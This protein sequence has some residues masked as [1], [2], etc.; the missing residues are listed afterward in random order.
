[1]GNSMRELEA[2]RGD[3]SVITGLAQDK[4]WSNGDG[5]GDHARA[6]ATFL[7]GMQA[8]KT[9]G[10]DIR[11]GV[12]VDQ[13][14]A[15]HMGHL[16][17]L[18]SLELSSDGQR[19][20]GRC[21][22]GYSCAYQF[23]LAWANET[24]P[25]P[26]E[27]DPRLVF[28]RMFGGGQSQGTEA[29][30]RAA[31]RTSILDTVLDDANRISKRANAQDRAKLDEYLT[32]VRDIEQRIQRAE[33]LNRP[34]PKGVVAPDS[35]PEKFEDHIHALLDLMVLAFQTDTTR[36]S[37]FLLSHDGSNRAFPDLGVPEAH[38]QLSH[39]SRDPEKLR[40]I[41]IIDRFYLRQFRYVLEKLKSV[42][43]GQGSL[44]D[45]CMIVYGSGIRDGDRH[46]HNELPLLLAGRGAGLKPGR[47]LA[48]G[49]QDTPMTNLY[50]SL[51]DRMGVPAERIGDS[52][53]RLGDI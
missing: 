27:M 8:K 30:R 22:S 21:D 35:I 1:M 29:K 41:A 20:A 15:Q 51:L 6:N 16:T 23:N 14:A 47:H 46:S 18:P 40:K 4:A 32:S 37:T 34:V 17:K 7:T 10:A 42:K 52:T 33:K 53:G 26:P 11:L 5:G 19:S 48:V 2:V 36:I 38:H 9:A 3:F 28:E 25:V 44:L 49:G 45:Q 13:I 43:E 50:L 12:S 31:L 24:T 39:H